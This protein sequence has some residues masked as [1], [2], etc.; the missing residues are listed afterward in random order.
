[1]FS[2]LQCMTFGNIC[3]TELYLGERVM[4]QGHNKL[5]GHRKPCAKYELKYNSDHPLRDSEILIL[6]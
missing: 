6:I 5:L 2:L 1:M 4:V 3:I